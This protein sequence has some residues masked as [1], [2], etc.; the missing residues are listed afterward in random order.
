M[1]IGTRILV[2]SLVVASLIAMFGIKLFISRSNLDAHFRECERIGTLHGKFQSIAEKD[3]QFLANL[4]QV[5]LS[6]SPEKLSVELPAEED[7]FFSDREKEEATLLD[8]E[9][10]SPLKEY[11][12]QQRLL[13][14]EAELLDGVLAKTP[15]AGD[16]ASYSQK[17]LEK[18]EKLEKKRGEINELF[19]KA[20]SG[21][22]QK[23]EQPGKM[24]ADGLILLLVVLAPLVLG[25]YNRKKMLNSI[26]TAT[27]FV[28]SLE[29]GTAGDHLPDSSDELGEVTSKI[30]S[31]SMGLK[32]FSEDMDSLIL[33]LSTGELTKRLRVADQKGM[34]LDLSQKLNAALDRLSAPVREILTVVSLQ[35]Q[36]DFQVIKTPFQGDF[37]AIRKSVNGISESIR[38]VTEELVSVS[39]A[40]ANSNFQVGV[41]GEYHGK[42][43]ETKNS[44]NSMIKNIGTMINSIKDF[45]VIFCNS[46]SDIKGLTTALA[47]KAES[48][49]LQACTTEEIS[50]SFNTMASTSE[51]ISVN[52][53]NILS[54]AEQMSQ[55][56][57]MVAGAIEH[58]S[59]SIANVATSAKDASKISGEAM[60]MAGS[61]TETMSSL[62]SAAREIGKV[63]EVIK[64]IAEQ[65][66]LLALN[67]TI[68]AASAGEAGKGFAVVAHEIKELANQSAQAAEGIANKISGVQ[69]N[70]ADA[71]R[72]ISD[73]SK[74]IKTIFES[75][76]LIS[77]SVEQQTKSANDISVNASE[78]AK[79]TSHIT[80]SIAEISKG[81][82]DMSA[83]IGQSAKKINQLANNIREV[84]ENLVENTENIKKMNEATETLYA[85]AQELNLLMQTFKI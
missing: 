10:V 15:T 54:T 81:T 20:K 62:G 37:E 40:L 53:S 75:V 33:G 29:T 68:E 8:K 57:N 74:I 77:E 30:H 31:F 64:R 12:N 18:Y 22:V 46:S 72:A 56:M 3:S 66:N 43:E 41:S 73:V 80:V 11:R 28:E 34:W 17:L 79:G 23:N 24:A 16:M 21:F 19:V 32:R 1:K 67:A 58:V 44:M 47:S 71:V 52:V 82:C 48:V 55:N 65:T 5:A 70:T 45:A 36:G 7:V 9:L 27:L 85:I 78:A 83:T 25:W 35:S 51:E 59:N 49:G 6:L 26:Q 39:A 60:R 38:S 76:G 61:A 2:S 69:G 4:V 63:T 84:S 42:L 13:L 14:R 50:N